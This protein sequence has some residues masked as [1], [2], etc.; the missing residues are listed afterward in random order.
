MKD[1][2]HLS[3]A[4]SFHH[5]ANPHG[6]GS[7]PTFDICV[8]MRYLGRLSRKEIFK[9][10]HHLQFECNEHVGTKTDVHCTPEET[11]PLVCPAAS[12]ALRPSSPS[13]AL[14][15]QGRQL[16][17]RPV[18]LSCAACLPLGAAAPRPTRL[19]LRLPQWPDRAA[20]PR[21]DVF[22]C[23]WTNRENKR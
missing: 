8:T 23:P 5:S 6:R 20:L 21:E 22:I 1:F 13:P 11:L 2:K 12:Q 18:F 15:P 16:A 7:V 3:G 19:T 14:T 10:C 9:G 4:Q 17:G